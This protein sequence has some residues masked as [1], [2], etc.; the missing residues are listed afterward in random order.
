MVAGHGNLTDAAPKSRSERRREGTRRR[1][2][3]AAYEII[4]ERGLEGLVIQEITQFA[5]VGYGTFYNHF[6]SKEAIVDAVIDAAFQRIMEFHQ[7]AS[8]I[9]PDA[10]DAFGMGMRVSLNE[11]KNDRMWG[12]FVIRSVLSGGQSFHRGVASHLKKR[13]EQCVAA[14]HVRCDDLDMARHVIGGLL[15][16]GTINLVS[17]EMT[18]DYEA[19][20]IET[21]LQALGI[22]EDRI[23][24]IITRPIP[25]LDLAA[26]LDPSDEMI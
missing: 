12:W 20:L 3:R 5:D 13:I 21:G 1:L 17:S 14:G 25:Q 23:R 24:T 9:W 15:L 6:P 10:V 8:A 19:R 16:I 2:M 22:S 7:R 11:A 4:A 18:E 26:F